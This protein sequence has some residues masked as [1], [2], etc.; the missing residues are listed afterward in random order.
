[1]KLPTISHFFLPQKTVLLRVLICEVKCC[2]SFTD[3]E[4]N[5]IYSKHSEV[6]NLY[7][8]QYPPE[9]LQILW[10]LSIAHIQEQYQPSATQTDGQ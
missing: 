2:P 8:E 5:T 7:C 4:H 3:T 10:E 1:M 9:P 6:C